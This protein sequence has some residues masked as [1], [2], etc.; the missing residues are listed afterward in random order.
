MLKSFWNKKLNIGYNVRK[1]LNMTFYIYR[2][3]FKFIHMLQSYTL[4]I[5]K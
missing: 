5:M 1:C 3:A 2:I 4:N